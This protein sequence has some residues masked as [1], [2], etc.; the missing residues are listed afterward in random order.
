MPCR[1]L[2][3]LALCACA[4]HVPRI[5]GPL[6]P[7]GRAPV[8]LPLER[9]IDRELEQKDRDLPRERLDDWQEAVVEAARHW[10]DST[11][12][13]FRDDCSGFVMAVLD[14]AGMPMS[15]S[16]RTFYGWA[17]DEGLLHRRKDPRPGDLAFFDDTYDR[18]RDGR[19]DDPLSHIAVVL[20]V[21]PDGTI[22]LAHGGT[23]RGRTTLT[24][25]LHHPDE[26]ADEDGKELNDWLR[27]EKGSDPPGTKYLAGELWRAFA[28]LEPGEAIAASN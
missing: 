9:T 8:P 27:A 1:L 7:V 6:G 24:M 22:T 5:P 4:S 14:R 16:T 23:S 20:S 10:L 19:T 28:T 17:E 12:R 18:D 11:P 13:G 26:R 21:D 25:N 15:G 3:L 2:P